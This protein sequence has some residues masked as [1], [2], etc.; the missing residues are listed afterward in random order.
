M[1]AI[2]CPQCGSLIKNVL[3]HQPIADCE[4]CGAKVITDQ[5]QTPEPFDVEAAKFRVLARVPTPPRPP[6]QSI[7]IAI[8]FI[9]VFFAVAFIISFLPPKSRTSAPVAPTPYQPIN[10][11]TP[12]PAIIKNDDDALL[13]F[14]GKGTSAGLFDGANAIAVAKNGDIYVADETRR[15]QRFDAN[16][17]FLN[18]WNV[19]GSKNETIDKLA[20]ESNG[21]VGVLIG[22]EIVVY[23]GETGERLRVLT[24]NKRHFIVDFVLLD[25]GSLM[26]VADSGGREEFVQTKSRK[27]V[28]RFA[29]KHGTLPE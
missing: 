28:N 11:P 23:K 24:D 25:D 19:E 1:K 6:V 5:P 14:G 17:K 13:K 18:L 16:G 22:G 7:F 8:A 9:G 26:Y 21:E 29:G 4:Y 12:T 10:F 2:S 27:I 20:V 15:V 3:S